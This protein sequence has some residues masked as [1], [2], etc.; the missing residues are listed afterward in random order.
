M[1]EISLKI[2]WKIFAFSFGSDVFRAVFQSFISSSV[3]DLSQSWYKSLASTET[4]FSVIRE[5]LSTK[6][7]VIVVKNHLKQCCKEKCHVKDKPVLNPMLHLIFFFFLYKRNNKRKFKRIKNSFVQII[8]VI[9]LLLFKRC[10]SVR[11]VFA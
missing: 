1:I 4:Y 9:N 3:L 5:E 10:L 8:N 11:I 2:F 7:Y 6:A